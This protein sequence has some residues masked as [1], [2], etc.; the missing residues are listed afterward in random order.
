MSEELRENYYLVKFKISEK[1]YYTFWYTDD[2]DGFLLDINGIIKSFPTKEKAV[3]FAQEKGF[4]LDT[5]EVL[6]SSEILKKTNIDCNLF[7]NYWNIFSD[8]AHSINC[9]FIGDSRKG[10][11]QQIYTKLFYGCNL[12]VKEN[13]EHY[14]PK[15]RKQEKRWI[16]RVIKDGF[17][18]L[19]KGL[20]TSRHL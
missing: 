4:L 15:W 5:K 14:K 8:A 9:Q 13:E 20:N 19:S 2:I 12:L 17:R 1:K 10:M 7:L 3:E 6:I 18:I 16:I 11:I